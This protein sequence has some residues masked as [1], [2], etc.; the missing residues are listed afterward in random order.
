MRLI[1]VAIAAV[2]FAAP[3]SAQCANGVCPLP[4]RSVASSP[5][6]Q[7]QY[8]LAPV[9]APRATYAAPVKPERR[10]IIGRIQDRR[11]LRLVFVR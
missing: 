10:G 5:A 6:P 9:A 8:A 4:N 11:A 2:V 3:A 7:F 1:L